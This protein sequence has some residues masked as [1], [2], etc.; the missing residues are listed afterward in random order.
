MIGLF[1]LGLLLLGAAAALLV[2]AVALPR[3]RV[4]EQLR[5][6]DTYGFGTP[7]GEAELATE[8]SLDGKLNALAE[9]VGRF[10]AA[11][12]E[13]VKPLPRKPLLAAGYYSLSPEAF[14]GYR[15]LAALSLPTLVVLNAIASAKPAV[16]TIALAMVTAVLGW[17]LPG[18]FIRQR[19]QNRLERVDR[20]LPELIDV[21][22]ATI[23]AG[24]GF[25]GSLQLVSER[26]QGPL[27]IELRLALQEQSMGLSTEQALSNMV[28]RCDTPSTR[29]F[30]RAVL[31]GEALGVS[32]GA[33]MRNLASDTRKRR[34]AAAQERI[35]KAPVKMLFPLV[36]LIFPAVLLVILGPAVYQLMQGLNAG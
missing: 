35:Q 17:Q 3:L 2:R 19:G 12:V 27:G 13:S 29:A 24:L 6:I 22:T 1:L 36:F 18:T 14:H 26:T 5:Q 30:V 10:T 16:T 11:H 34:R 25:A 28:D 31:Q 33:M 23:E 7:A 8:R 21:L 20:D 32:I 9:R 4:G 15:V